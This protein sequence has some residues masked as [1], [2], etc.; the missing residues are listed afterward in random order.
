MLSGRDPLAE[1]RVLPRPHASSGPSRGCS[2]LSS[3]RPTSKSGRRTGEKLRTV[4]DVPMGDT[5]PIN[6]VLTGPRDYEWVPTEPATLLWVEALDKGDLRNK[7]PHR[8]RLLTLQ[9]PLHRPAHRS[10]EDRVSLQRRDFTDKGTILLTESDRASRTTRTWVLT[11]SWGAAAQAVGPQ[12]AGL[13]LE[14]R[15]RRCC[16]PG[17]DTV[18]QVGD[19]IY[20]TG[21]RRLEGRR[22]SVPRPP[23]PRDAADR[24]ALPLR[25]QD[26]GDGRRPAQR[27]RQT[28]DD[29]RRDPH[30]AARTTS[31]ASCRATRRRRSPRSRTRIRR[32]PPAERMFVTYPRKDGVTMSGTIYLPPGYTKGTRVPM[33]VWAYPREFVDA[34]AA[35]QV[36]GSPNRFT[37]VGGVLAPA[38]ARARLRDFRWPDDADHRRRERRRTTPT[39]SSSCRARRPPSTRRSSSASR[40]AT[41][42]ASAAT[43]TA[44][45]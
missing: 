10:R 4:A 37:T 9:G 42:S 34:A 27:R 20:L 15:A 33:L 19:S 16:R 18:L 2:S 38:A 22:P 5:V 32:S 1:R 25:R 44:R 28:R 39:S 13:L 26:P 40:I 11:S 29:P 31:S 41:A 12:A 21:A 24:A 30:A 36:V 8:D 7:V 6:G 35:S 14:S 17:K 43:A 3:S 45:S 23:Q